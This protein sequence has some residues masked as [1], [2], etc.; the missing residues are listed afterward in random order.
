MNDLLKKIRNKAIK[1]DLTNISHSDKV[2]IKQS[3]DRLKQD[4]LIFSPETKDKI[5][6]AIN[7]SC[8]K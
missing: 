4:T 3:L 5:E 1:I 8:L 6:K 2:A 7:E